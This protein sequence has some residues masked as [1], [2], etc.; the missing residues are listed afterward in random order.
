MGKKTLSNIKW[1]QG[2]G[3]RVSILVPFQ[4]VC[5]MCVWGGENQEET[6]WHRNGAACAFPTDPIFDE[7]KLDLISRV[8]G[9]IFHVKM[10]L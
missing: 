1:E 8:A 3:K 4:D 7:G 2:H 6:Q 9:Y 10:C 5:W